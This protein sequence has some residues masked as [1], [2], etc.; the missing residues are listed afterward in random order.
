M[1]IEDSIKQLVEEKVQ[2]ATKSY[3][4]RLASENY[5]ISEKL[6]WAEKKLNELVEKLSSRNNNFEN[7]E[8]S[9]DKISGGK[10]SKFSSTGIK[11]TAPNTMLTVE[12]DKVVVEKNL[13]VN[14]TIQ[15]KQLL[16]NKAKCNDLEV[17]NSV[18]INGTEVLWAD[19]LGNAVKKSKLTE[20]GVLNELN[21]ADTLTIFK[22]K[23]GVNVIEPI[24]PFGVAS[25]GIEVSIDAKG[26]TGYVGTVNSDPFAIGSSG[27]PTLYISPDNKVGIKIKKPKAD[28][29]VAGYIRYQGQTQQYLNS[30][31]NAGTWAQGDIVWNSQPGRGSVLGWVCIKQGSPGTWRPFVSID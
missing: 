21:V 19:R 9:G 3:Y 5:S 7:G 4:T 1:S 14:G 8:I 15:V 31:P 18:R 11:D 28:L 29:D 6:K 30:I 20:L 22:N 12:K 13:H 26:D 10:I 16:Y 17:D 24:G 2:K 25:N 27:D 23:V